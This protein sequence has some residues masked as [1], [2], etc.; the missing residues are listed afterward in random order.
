MEREI[1][2]FILA[3][4]QKST[5]PADDVTQQNILASKEWLRAIANGQLVVSIPKVKKDKKRADV[6]PD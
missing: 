3:M 5:M 2:K 1:A 4:I 6:K